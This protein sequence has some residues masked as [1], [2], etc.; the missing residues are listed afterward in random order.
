MHILLYFL[1]TLHVLVC[2][3]M[4]LVVLMQRPRSEG[5]G[6]AF[7]SG[8][9]ENIF[10][11]QT[12]NVLAKFTT[13]LGGGFF[14]LTLALAMVYARLYSGNTGIEKELMKL[15]QPV[16]SA[17]PKPVAAPLPALPS[18]APTAAASVQPASAP[19]PTPQPA[20]PAASAPNTPV[21]TPA[22]KAN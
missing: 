10:G 6:A 22:S 3:L 14:V 5:L 8:M 19:P 20:T 4:V 1:L 9:T 18:P 17:T 15:P 13:W 16:A 2:L 7:G 21:A 11:A 12:S